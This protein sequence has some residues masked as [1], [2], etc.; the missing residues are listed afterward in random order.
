MRAELYLPPSPPLLGPL[1]R[2]IRV[3]AP[4]LI[5]PASS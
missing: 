3:Y 4:D 5:Q 2:I 1:L